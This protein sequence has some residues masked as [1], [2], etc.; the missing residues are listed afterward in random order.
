MDIV[1]RRG[2]ATAAEIHAAMPDAPT[3]TT[4][5]GLLRV[6][7]TK[8]LLTHR[9]DGPRYL[10]E[11]VAPREQMGTS[12]LVQIAR[13][14]FGGSASDAAAALLGSVS[15]PLTPDEIRRLEDVVSRARG[16]PR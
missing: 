13:S 6:L 3:Y 9:E 15:K 12:Y 5:R 14:F 7:E 11:P 10:Y 4:V 2:A 8:G 16:R 1:Y